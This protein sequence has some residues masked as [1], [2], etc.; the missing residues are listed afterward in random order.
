MTNEQARAIL[1][2]AAENV[3]G[4]LCEDEPLDLYDALELAIDALEAT[5]WRD[6][7]YELPEKRRPVLDECGQLVYL[8]DEGVWRYMDDGVTD[9]YNDMK[10]HVSS[11]IPIPEGDKSI[12]IKPDYDMWALYSTCGNDPDETCSLCGDTSF[13]GRYGLL[14]SL[15]AVA[16]DQRNYCPN[17]GREID[18]W[19]H[20]RPKIGQICGHKSL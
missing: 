17:C 11:W 6:P 1:I 13:E 2:S 3:L 4:E 7:R 19:T 10:V 18:F 9:Y 16:E 20:L 8:D 12:P 5:R 14:A 15:Q